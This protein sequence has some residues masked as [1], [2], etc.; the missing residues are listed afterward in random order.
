MTDSIVVRVTLDSYDLLSNEKQTQVYVQIPEVG[1]TS[2]LLPAELFHGLKGRS[3]PEVL[4]VAHEYVTYGGA[5]SN[6]SSTAAWRAIREWL[7]EDANRDEV[8]AAFEEDCAKRD[9]VARKLLA[10]VGR[11][12]ARVA[13]LEKPPLSW[14]DRLDAKSLDNFLVVLGSATEHEPMSEAIGRVNEVIHSFRVAVEAEAA[15]AVPSSKA[16]DAS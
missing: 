7:L 13:E 6:S 2:W 14:T 4:D 10:E 11:L 15:R 12:R 5:A 9:P 1:R 16:G 3:W 8:Q